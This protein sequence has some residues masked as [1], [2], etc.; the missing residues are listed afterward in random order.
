MEN[1]ILAEKIFKTKFAD[2]KITDDK[3]IVFRYANG[4][5]AHREIHI[6]RGIY[7]MYFG[8]N[9]MPEDLDGDLLAEFFEYQ[10][11]NFSLSCPENIFKCSDIL[12]GILENKTLDD[13]LRLITDQLISTGKF[14][15]IGLM[16]F[17]EAVM[18]LRCVLY[19]ISEGI[20]ESY[21]DLRGVT[22][23][24]D[25]KSILT[26]V[27]FYNKVQYVEYENIEYYDEIK[28]CF[29]NDVL[30]GN[31]YSK[32]GPTGVVI[33]EP[34]YYDKSVDEQFKF[35]LR[36]ISL[37]VELNKMFKMY[38]FALEDIK[39]FKENMAKTNSLAQVGKFAA[40]V[41]HEIKN[42]LVAIGGFASKL[43]KY[44]TDSKG[45]TYLN[46]VNMEIERLDRIVSDI[47]GY[48]R[49][50]KLNFVNTTVGNIVNQVIE[51]VSEKLSINSIDVKLNME[52]EDEFIYVDEK[53]MKQVL[54]N[55]VENAIHAME[56]GGVLKI[57]SKHCQDRMIINVEDSGPGI[58]PDIINKVFEPFFSTKDH[59]TGLGLA[60]CK[61]ILSKHGGNIYMESGSSGTKVTV[62]LP[63]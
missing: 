53:R 63:L 22:I 44:I 60:I 17:N 25:G 18:S 1:V 2:I 26:D 58:P 36:I 24:L 34:S 38:D 28:K 5:K 55:I 7:D 39:Y 59:G 50:T 40:T 29:K 43:E 8:L 15:R 62:E 12:L 10:L 54:L 35:Y 56:E 16:L 19:V 32:N 42:P 47:L 61:E 6:K 57:S 20:D 27:L 48:S 4:S 45:R 23:H 14:K 41:A 49:Q 37:A 46:I 3:E 11:K 13:S 9:I 51:L 21:R 31:I 52:N 30:V 33:A